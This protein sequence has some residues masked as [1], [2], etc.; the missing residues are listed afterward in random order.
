[1][2]SNASIYRELCGIFDSNTL[3]RRAAY[4]KNKMELF[5]EAS[6]ATGMLY[7]DPKILAHVVV[8][9]FTDIYKIKDFNKIKNTNKAKITA[10]TA[11]WLCRRKPIQLSRPCTDDSFAFVNEAFVTTYIVDEMSN[12]NATMKTPEFIKEN[13]FYHLKYRQYDAQSIELMINA[14]ITGKP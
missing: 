14:N 11:F 10:Y 3:H 4:L 7:V 2:E 13:L 8:D 6:D 5:I 12:L 9:Y 1:M